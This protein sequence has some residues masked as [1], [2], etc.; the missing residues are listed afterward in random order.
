MISVPPR[1]QSSTDVYVSSNSTESAN[2]DVRCG[3]KSEELSVDHAR[4]PIPNTGSCGIESSGVT[5]ALSRS[6]RLNAAAEEAGEKARGEIT[7]A[8]R[9]RTICRLAGNAASR[10][11]LHLWG[12]WDCPPASLLAGEESSGNKDMT[13]RAG[14]VDISDTECN[15]LQASG[16]S[17]GHFNASPLGSIF[18]GEF[19]KKRCI[20]VAANTALGRMVS[21]DPE[22]AAKYDLVTIPA[23]QLN[24]PWPPPAIGPRQLVKQADNQR[25]AKA[26][27]MEEEKIARMERAENRRVVMKKRV[28]K[29]QAVTTLVGLGLRLR[30]TRERSST[31]TEDSEALEDAVRSANSTDGFE[32][33][34]LESAGNILDWAQKEAFKGIFNRYSK[35]DDYKLTRR[36][37]IKA[38][39]EAG[40]TPTTQEEQRRFAAVQVQVLE[41]TRGEFEEQPENNPLT[42]PQG[43]WEMSEFLLVCAA[44]REINLRKLR[45]ANQEASDEFDVPLAEVEELRSVF[46]RYDSESTGMITAQ[47]MK[48]LLLVVDMK[49]S[50]EDFKLLLQSAGLHKERFDFKEFLKLTTSLDSAMKS[51]VKMVAST[52]EKKPPSSPIKSTKTLGN[53]QPQE[54]ATPRSATPRANTSDKKHSLGISSPLKSMRTLGNLQ[55]SSGAPTPRNRSVSRPH[56]NLQRDAL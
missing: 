56:L 19:P 6:E 25:R 43:R 20:K 11:L 37:M 16:G 48:E 34:D 33:A 3:S 5:A 30:M 32:M 55:S 2:L 53:L 17:A 36:G 26:F 40:L 9:A 42:S 49:T 28:A 1:P 21:A 13:E 23:W 39:R 22:R 10:K 51:P 46:Q 41:A 35:H 27:E 45:V 8:M 7:L 47:D 38:M 44:L 14:S 52:S 29:M 54:A 18:G 15:Q 24:K 31:R 12:E 4:T 50:D